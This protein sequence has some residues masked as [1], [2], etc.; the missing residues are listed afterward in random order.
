MRQKR[1]LGLLGGLKKIVSY[2][3]SWQKGQWQSSHLFLQLGLKIRTAEAFCESFVGEKMFIGFP[4]RLSPSCSQ[5]W[6]AIARGRRWRPITQQ[7]RL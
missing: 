1:S 3:H 4:R 2:Y 6:C 5:A 7:T